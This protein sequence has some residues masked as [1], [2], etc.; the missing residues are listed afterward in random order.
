MINILKNKVLVKN[1]YPHLM[2]K[3]EIVTQM[4]INFH[5]LMIMLNKKL[6]WI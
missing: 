3:K 5:I 4:M 2:L 6:I 1:I